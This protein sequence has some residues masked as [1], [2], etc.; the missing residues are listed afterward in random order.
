MHD[1]EFYEELEKR[2]KAGTLRYLSLDEISIKAGSLEI[3]SKDGFGWSTVLRLDGKSWQNCTRVV[4]IADASDEPIFVA[5]E[6]DT[7]ARALMDCPSKEEYCKACKAID[8]RKED[9]PNRAPAG[10]QT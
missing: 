10:T 2:K 4:F 7:S 1:A 6:I 3:E 5:V 8:D 9:C